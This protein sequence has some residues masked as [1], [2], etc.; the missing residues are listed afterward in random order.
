MFLEIL[1][2]DLK[3]NWKK[4]WVEILNESD[5]IEFLEKKFKKY[6]LTKN[7]I[8][9]NKENIFQAF[10]YFDLHETKL[11]FLGQDPYIGSKIENGIEIP[12]ATGLAFS[13]LDGFKHPP[14]LKNIFKEISNEY[15]NFKIPKS[16]NLERWAKEEKILLLNTALTV[17]KGM[18]NSHQKNWNSVINNVISYI[19]INCDCVIFLLLGN[20]AKS[21]IKLIDKRKHKVI[22]GI[23]PSPLSA[24]KG[25]FGSDVFKRVNNE[26]LNLGKNEIIW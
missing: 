17:K 18:S 12:Q 8:F 1:L 24:N 3:P 23:H 15:P 22:T 11:V 26:L 4:M 10:K 14:S 6:D 19:S 21:K 16:G 13:V 5:I 9:P 20:N 25:F 2:N 7:K